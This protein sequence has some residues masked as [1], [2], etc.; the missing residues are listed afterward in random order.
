MKLTKGTTELICELERIIGNEC[1]NP[2][3]YNG[4]T[5]EEGCEFR[6][7]VWYENKDGNDTKTYSQISNI[8]KSKI[9]TI[10]YKFGSNFL[11][12]GLAI[13][14]VLERLE[15]RFG[16]DFNEL[17]KGKTSKSKKSTN[18][19]LQAK[20]VEDSSKINDKFK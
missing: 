17:T 1:Y 16:L 13:K 14:E 9:N 20:I 19:I 11:Y 15:A 12:I 10:R 2:N 5:L 3:S 4:Y 8:D 18:G 6:Y 7:P